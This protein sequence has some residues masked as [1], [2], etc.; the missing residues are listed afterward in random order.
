MVGRDQAVRIAEQFIIENGYGQ[1]RGDKNKLIYELLDQDFG[2]TDSVL[3]YRFNSINPKAFCFTE[4]KTDWYIGFLFAD[5][6]VKVLDSP[7]ISDWPG[8]AVLVAKNGRSIRIAHKMPRFSIF[9][10]L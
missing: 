7:R 6:D 1:V 4:S 10:R 3:A 2:N 9:S 5:V 8:R